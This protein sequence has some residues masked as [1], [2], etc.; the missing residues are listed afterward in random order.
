[1]QKRVRPLSETGMP[2]VLWRGS[3]LL[4]ILASCAASS[5]RAASVIVR[6]VVPPVVVIHDGTQTKIPLRAGMIVADGDELIGGSKLASV[7]LECANG[8]TQTLSADFH[9]IVNARSAK[10][11]CAIDL[12]SGAAV[13]TALAAAP[14]TNTDNDASISGGIYAMT[15]HHTQFGLIVT[16]RG[17][18]NAEAFVIDGEARV[19][20]PSNPDPMTLKDGQLV[21]SL[22]GTVVRIS[23]QVFARV[24]T[25]YAALDL[26]QLGGMATAK[27]AATLRSQWLA[28]LQQPGN[29]NAR[30]ALAQTHRQLKLNAS[31]VSQYQ[32]ARG[33]A[34]ASASASCPAKA[35][36][37]SRTF[38][39]P[40]QGVYRL[41]YCLPN[42]Q[43]GKQTAHAWCQAQGYACAASW[44]A[45][46]DIGDK[47]PTQRMGGKE[48]CARGPCDGFAAITCQ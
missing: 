17:K 6:A 21:S 32:V 13:A 40:M 47:T 5:A 34:S 24:A 23:E 42:N 1:M 18:E 38:R 44:K 19:S 4:F 27:I 46:I 33:N 39:N 9:A 45:D 25:A 41:D 8:A 28:T 20:S 2:F 43:C 30:K 7:Q 48:V 31:L 12:K 26:A 16:P 22:T 36:P 35:L 3:V 11:R 37:T 15:S 29:L 10:T 14:N